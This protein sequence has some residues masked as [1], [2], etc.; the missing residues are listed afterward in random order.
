MYRAYGA[1][2]ASALMRRCGQVI[3]ATSNADNWHRREIRDSLLI[4]GVFAVTW[5]CSH[6]FD[7]APKFFQFGINN[8]EWEVD[9]LIFVLC[10]MSIV[11]A[12]YSF[13]RMK[14]LV[15]EMTARRSAEMEARQLAR[16]DPLTGLPNRRYFVEKLT[17]VLSTTTGSSRSAVLMLD[18]DGFKS[19]NDAY[20]HLVGDRALTMFAERISATMRSGAILTRIG[21]DEFAV[22]APDIGSLDTPTSL[23]RRIASTTAEP[24][25]IE[26]ISAKLGVGIGISIAPEDGTD[27]EVLVQRAD[28]ALYRAK[29]EGH[30]CIRFFEPGMDAHVERRIAIE[31]ELRAAIADKLIVPH[32]QP[33]VAFEGSR[34]IGFEALARWKSDKF[35]WVEPDVFITVA[36]EI[37][38]ISELGDQLLHQACLD[39]RTW[40]AKLTLAFNISATQLC[41][42]ALGLRVLAILGE[43]GFSPR[44][45]ELEI[46][47]TALIDHI[48]VAQNVIDELR[49][50]GVRIAL[51]DFGTGYATLSQLLSL[52]LDRIK[53]DRSF[54]GRVGKDKEGTTVVRA[55]LGLANAFGLATTAEGIED[56]DQLASLKAS[57]CKEGQGYLFGKAVPANE[58]PGVLA[59]LKPKIRDAALA[60]S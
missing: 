9:D 30:S 12:I 8:A 1:Q 11:L 22:I 13:R 5:A 7:L 2:R 23:A 14:D 17:E 21:G 54:I 45:L 26:N 3:R 24:Y 57:G 19:I 36:E 50:A 16:H 39:A 31:N 51:D 43:T 46:T 48:A 28:R 47:E 55:I 10:V 42:P 56:V 49:Q 40:P 60:M 37:G 44:L 34:V 53:I 38:L 18:L 41:D 35:G 25:L 6:W 52:H 15:R 20:G 59:K 4:L 58:I 32:Y 33:V 29:A 27:P